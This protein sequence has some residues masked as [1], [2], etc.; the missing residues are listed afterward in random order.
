M[1]E[2]NEIEEESNPY[3]NNGL[4]FIKD[5]EEVLSDGTNKR[6][7]PLLIFSFSKKTSI[8]NKEKVI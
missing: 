6:N 2:Q 3:K 8:K 7:I 5:Y 1:D 4:P